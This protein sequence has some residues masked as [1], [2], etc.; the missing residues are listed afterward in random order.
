MCR[1]YSAAEAVEIAGHPFY[2]LTK[3]DGFTFVY[4]VLA[5]ELLG[6]PIW[7]ER[8]SYNRDYWLASTYNYAFDRHLIGNSSNGNIYEMEILDATGKEG[9]DYVVAEAVLPVLWS[10]AESFS[11]NSLIVDAATGIGNTVNPAQDPRLMMAI[12]RDGGH[13]WSNEEWRSL[14]LRGERT[15]RCK[16]D[17]LGDYDRASIRLQ[18]SDPVERTLLG[19]YADVERGSV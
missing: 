17:A 12:S 15:A 4:D 9:D 8:Q 11:I 10:N 14:G 1:R 7:H 19:A 5:S 16:W 2:V 18:I 3:P 6:R 13:A